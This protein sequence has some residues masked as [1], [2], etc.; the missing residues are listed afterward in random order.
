[1][2][3]RS[4]WV[5]LLATSLWACGGTSITDGNTGGD[6]SGGATTGGSGG[7]TTGGSGGASTGGSG[8]V[9]GLECSPEIQ[10][11]AS[12]GGPPVG[13]DA[14]PGAPGPVLVVSA[15]PDSLELNAGP[16]GGT[17]SFHWVGSDLGQKFSKGE[18]VS[19]GNSDGWDYVMGNAYTAVARHDYGFVAPDQIP[20]MPGY[21]PHLGYAPQCSFK[22]QSGACNQPPAAVTVLALEA[23]TGAGVVDIA[24]GATETFMG[25]EIDNAN[26]VQF[27]GYSGNDCVLE[28]GFAGIITALGPALDMAQ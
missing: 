24:F 2:L 20:D 6:G 11:K 1:M 25:W 12:L 3:L 13:F 19:I 16:D 22:E 7:A 23:T 8:G 27:P 14:L 4:S 28:A 10:Q 5:G 17:F 21:G 26:N 18:M 15:L 9:G